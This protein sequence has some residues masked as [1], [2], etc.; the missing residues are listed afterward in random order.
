[1]ER[2]EQ[3]AAAWAPLARD[4]V[5]GPRWWR[6]VTVVVDGPGAGARRA[7]IWAGGQLLAAALDGLV[8]GVVERE[9]VER[10][11]DALEPY[12]HG[13]GYAALPGGNERYFDDNAWVGLDFFQAAR[14]LVR[15][16]LLDRA[17]GVLTF[18]HTGMRDGGVYW[19]EGGPPTR[20]TCSTGPTAE[21]AL[22]L[23]LA[24]DAHARTIGAEARGF[25]DGT[26][27]RD[28]GLYADHIHDDGTVD[29]TIWSYNQGTPVGAA[30]LWFRLTGETAAVDAARATADAA[31][32]HFGG[33]DRLWTQP[34]AFNA[35]FFRNLLL[36]DALAGYPPAL[37]ALVGYLDRVWAEA[38]QPATGWFSE[39]G[40]GRYEQ[41]GTLDQAGIAQLFALAAWPRDRWADIC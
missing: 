9:A 24:G 19:L 11:V 25:L 32:D 23:A 14:I 17:R 7:G 22:R 36:F 30:A 10:L 15:D 35:I 13:L 28:D 41:G 21:L 4:V 1:M 39:G 2:A 29:P 40:I 6:P 5:L 8:A 12:R 37:P 3:A 18:L 31:L 27:R 16:D 26:L 33:D 20:H 34:P 38:R